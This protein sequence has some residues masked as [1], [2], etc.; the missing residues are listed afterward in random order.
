MKR[1][2]ETMFEKEIIFHPRYFLKIIRRSLR[3]DK[4]RRDRRNRKSIARHCTT[5]NPLRQAHLTQTIPHEEP[6]GSMAF[7]P[8]TAI[9]NKKSETAFPDLST[10]GDKHQPLAKP[11]ILS[12]LFDDFTRQADLIRFLTLHRAKAECAGKRRTIRARKR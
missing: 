8:G 9:Q 5:T 2:K 1:N 11:A 12:N 7:S 3:T 4:D 10:Y 6:S